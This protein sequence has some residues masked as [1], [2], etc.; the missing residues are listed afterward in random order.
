MAWVAWRN[1]EVVC[2]PK[3]VTD[4]ST[5]WARRRVVSLIRPTMLPL[6]YFT[7]L[8]HLCFMCEITLYVYCNTFIY[9]AYL[10]KHFACIM[11]YIISIPVLYMLS[12]TFRFVYKPNTLSDTFMVSEM[13]YHVSYVALIS[14]YPFTEGLLLL[15]FRWI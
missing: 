13:T 1:I 8:W 4:L 10:V 9:S 3:T 7:A 5:N 11:L 15:N 6:R 2:P 12:L 14:T